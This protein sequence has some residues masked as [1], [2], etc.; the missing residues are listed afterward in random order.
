MRETTTQIT[1]GTPPYSVLLSR[2][3]E[4]WIGADGSG[5]SRSEFQ[6]AEF[7]SDE[8][9][10]AWEAAGRPD[11]S[12]GQVEEH[13][14]SPGE[15]SYESFRDLPTDPDLLFT[16]IQRRAGTAGPGANPEMFI[17][18]GDL[19]RATSVPSDLRA[20]L[21]RAAERIPGVQVSERIIDPEG[22]PGVGLSLTYNDQ[23]GSLV[24]VER[25][26]DPQTTR[27]LAEQKLVTG[28]TAQDSALPS[29]P[30]GAPVP[31]HTLEGPSLGAKPG[32]LVSSTVYLN[33]GI[34]EAPGEAPAP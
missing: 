19:L 13:T 34:A 30:P 7:P 24:K 15:L 3:V 5:R 8:D 21:F 33:S 26:F 17:V 20:S 1:G 10:A 31:P 22:R 27:L 32:T 16:E 4:T 9:R 23:N 6:R 14:Y 2:V 12:S 18:I 25:V 11:F 28:K 29:R